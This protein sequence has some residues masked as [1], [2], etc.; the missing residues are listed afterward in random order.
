[1]STRSPARTAAR[2][3]ACRRRRTKCSAASAATSSSLRPPE[4]EPSPGPGERTG[5]A[6]LEELSPRNATG[7][8]RQPQPKGAF[9][10][11]AGPWVR[12]PPP[13]CPPSAAVGGRVPCANGRTSFYRDIGGHPRRAPAGVATCGVLVWGGKDGR[14]L[15]VYMLSHGSPTARASHGP[16]PPQ[17]TGGV[18]QRVARRPS[19]DLGRDAAT[20][21][22]VCG[23]K[24]D[25]QFSLLI[26]KA[27]RAFSGCAKGL[28]SFFLN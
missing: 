22:H 26:G 23:G 6:T 9:F 18:G 16:F 28:S 7:R 3:S 5:A 8:G 4:A 14:A 24:G 11:S 2:T 13:L 15:G 20:R 21:P 12:R 19:R 10:S 27:K 17:T 1:M 25:L